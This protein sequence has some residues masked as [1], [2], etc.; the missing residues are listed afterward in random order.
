MG[1]GDTLDGEAVAVTVAVEGV[2][3]AVDSPGYV[4][5]GGDVDSGEG[6]VSSA[7]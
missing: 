6:S 1:S 5:A 7:F 2:A 3:G 4:D